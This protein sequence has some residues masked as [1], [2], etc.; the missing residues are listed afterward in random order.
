MWTLVVMG[1]GRW[2]YLA[3]AL[4]SVEATVGLE[5]FDRKVA[6]FDGCQPPDPIRAVFDSVWTSDRRKGLT[7]NLGRA[8]G[9]LDRTDEYVFHLEEDFVLMDAP[10]GEM[11]ATL[12]VNRDVA[13]MVL[14]RQPWAPHEAA[15][16]IRAQP[17]MKIAHG[18]WVE[19]QAGFWLNPMVAHASLLRSL[20][21]AVEADL[22]AQC[23]ARGYSFGYWG[24]LDDEPRCL[25]VGEVGGMGSPGWLP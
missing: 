3:R 12:E 25:H 8:W 4:E 17:G 5:F 24:G 15:G 14:A 13:N 7:A 19:H 16:V 18:R 1:H 10:L 2:P 23:R 20:K 9:L 6:A 22:T 11:A 21:P